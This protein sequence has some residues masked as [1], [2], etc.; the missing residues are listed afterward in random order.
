MAAMLTRA[1]GV[2]WMQDSALDLCNATFFDNTASGSGGAIYAD[3][4]SSLSGT[5]STFAN[6]TAG[7]EGG[8]CYHNGFFPMLP[9][10]W[11]QV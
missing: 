1:G 3:T 8:A 2:V 7:R 5:D 11:A 9:G 6:N 10:R 4:D